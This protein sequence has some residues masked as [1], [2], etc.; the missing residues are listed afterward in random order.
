MAWR[1]FRHAK[2]LEEVYQLLLSLDHHHG[3]I[4]GSGLTISSVGG[5]TSILG[6]V[7]HP[8][9]VGNQTVSNDGQTIISVPHYVPKSFVGQTIFS[10]RA[11]TPTL[12]PHFRPDPDEHQI[13]SSGHVQVHTSVR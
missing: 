3:L 10:V 4:P 5:Q 2:S 13:I 7:S 8:D 11:P 12:G 1:N 9:P 6:R